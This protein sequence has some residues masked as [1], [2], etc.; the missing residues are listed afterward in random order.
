MQETIDALLEKI[1]DPTVRAAISAGWELGD[2]I[3]SSRL[4][5]YKL[6]KEIHST[7]ESISH[8]MNLDSD[9][10]SSAALL[11]MAL[12]KHRLV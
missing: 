9:I 3:P 2:N 12:G 1:N 5:D 8:K 10:V 7:A 6:K 11:S 4:N